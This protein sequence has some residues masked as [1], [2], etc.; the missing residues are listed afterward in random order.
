MPG[1]VNLVVVN[2]ASKHGLKGAFFAI[3]GTNAASLVLIAAG[4][5]IVGLG[6]ID[7]NLLTWLSAAGGIYL[8][9]Y[10]WHFYAGIKKVKQEEEKEDIAELPKI[11][12]HSFMVGISNPKDVIFHDV[13]SAVYQPSE[14][15]FGS[16]SAAR[17]DLVHFGLR[18]FV[19]IRLGRFQNHYTQT[20]KSRPH[21]YLRVGIYA[22]FHA[23]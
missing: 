4:L 6:K 21:H 10:G 23:V 15:G 20:R 2:T 22:V 1:L 14:Y 8:I 13:F 17:T 3:I 5:M 9:Y 12:A 18:H 7:Q 19:G 11:M 16:K